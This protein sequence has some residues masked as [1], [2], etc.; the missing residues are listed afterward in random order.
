[1]PL[2]G[3][4]YAMANSEDWKGKQRLVE[5]GV[6]FLGFG[7]FCWGFGQLVWSYY[8]FFENIAAPY[9]S[10]ADIGFAPTEFL[11]CMGLIC[12]TKAV[13]ADF[14]KKH[15]YMKFFVALVSIAVF[16]VSYYL[17]VLMTKQGLFFSATD[18]FLVNFFE[19]IYLVSSGLSCVV[20]G[21]VI[22][23]LSFQFMRKEYKLALISIISGP[24]LMFISDMF[25]SYATNKGSF[26][27][28]V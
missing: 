27:M 2:I 11:Y 24:G 26:L 17:L 20:F 23:G 28:E 25:F 6:F 4:Y 13:G 19:I 15:R 18:S 5:K 16:A 12:L 8:N 10:L 7:V 14:T 9:P 22:S 1:M 21:V 3:G